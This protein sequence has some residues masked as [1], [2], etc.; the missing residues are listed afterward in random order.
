MIKKIKIYGALGGE[1]VNIK[2]IW[3]EMSKVW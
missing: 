2:K 3:E 1:K